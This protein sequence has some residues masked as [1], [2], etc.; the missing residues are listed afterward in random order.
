M[1]IRQSRE[2]VRS[3][4]REKHQS[5][6]D[7]DAD[8]LSPLKRTKYDKEAETGHGFFA[9]PGYH[10]IALKNSNIC[11]N[12]FSSQRSLTD[13]IDN[14]D[15]DVMEATSH[16]PQCN[17]RNNLFSSTV[18]PSLSGS[19]FRLPPHNLVQTVFSTTCISAPTKKATVSSAQTV[20]VLKENMSDI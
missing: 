14:I 2:L 9:L 1:R 5:H 10:G 20:S 15:V 17:T 4:N 12:I 16:R 11:G 6:H 3:Q 13:N 18:Y 7:G 19:G 8:E